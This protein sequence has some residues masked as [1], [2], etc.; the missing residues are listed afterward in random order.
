MNKV[1]FISLLVLIGVKASFTV[2]AQQQ[3]PDELDVRHIRVSGQA[4]VSSVPDMFHFS[5]YLE[6]QGELASK[7]NGIVSE[8]STQIV[9]LLLK[10]GLAESDIQSMR[11]QLRPWFEHKQSTRVQK[12]FVLSRQIKIIMRNADK[13]NDVIDGLLRLGAN[14][15]EGFDYAIND[16]KKY[17]LASLEL[18]L[19][20]AGVRAT[21]MAKVM[22]LKVG[23]V[24]S[25]EEASGY[26]PIPIARGSK[27]MADSGAYLPGEISTSARVSVVFALNDGISAQKKK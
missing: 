16:P 1:I 12:G 4:S 21:T 22:G 2:R 8:K 20:D 23:E 27:L 3:V 26:A 19:A 6:E 13:Y 18:A 10:A 25:I 17:Y 24:L 9:K 14:R 7:L 11:V 5:V 15:I